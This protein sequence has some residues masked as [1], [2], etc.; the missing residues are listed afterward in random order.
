VLAALEPVVSSEVPSVARLASGDGR[1]A[2]R[3]DPTW[4]PVLVA[5]VVVAVSAVV[6]LI[7]VVFRRLR[8]DARRQ[9]GTR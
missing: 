1:G 8:I 3:L 9:G 5:F 6:V 7:V 2:G 4:P